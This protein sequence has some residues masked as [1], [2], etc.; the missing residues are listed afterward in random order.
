V[1]DGKGRHKSQLAAKQRVQQLR[2]H[3]LRGEL[4]TWTVPVTV[5]AS[6]EIRVSI[7]AEQHSSEKSCRVAGERILRDWKTGNE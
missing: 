7:R 4:V 6:Y 2:V 1:S 3:E 5:L